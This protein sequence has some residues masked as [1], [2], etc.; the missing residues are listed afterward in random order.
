MAYD[1]GRDMYTEL[2]EAKT[3][4]Q[5]QEKKVEKQ[6]INVLRLQRAVQALE[7]DVAS[8]KIQMEMHEEL[9]RQMHEVMRL[10]IANECLV[11]ENAKLQRRVEELE[12]K[13]QC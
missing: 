7:G 2:G 6:K 4:L 10:G 8:R 5:E 1:N 3:Q 13:F 11:A 12:G 9:V